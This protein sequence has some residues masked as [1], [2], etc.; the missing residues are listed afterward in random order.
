MN[1]D[2]TIPLPHEYNR[3]LIHL[4]LFEP[5]SFVIS[6]RVCPRGS[7]G[8]H[9]YRIHYYRSRRITNSSLRWPLLHQQ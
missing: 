1:Y 9:Y 8:I 6:V 4:N 3:D 2:T 7:H 5:H